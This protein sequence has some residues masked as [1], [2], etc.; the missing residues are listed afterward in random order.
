MAAVRLVADV[1][2]HHNRATAPL[3]RARRG[4]SRPGRRAAAGQR[5]LTQ[6]SLCPPARVAVE[7]RGI[8]GGAEYNSN[9]R[10]SRQSAEQKSTAVRFGAPRLVP[11]QHAA[12]RPRIR[13][14]SEHLDE[15]RVVADVRRLV[16]HAAHQPLVAQLAVDD[17]LVAH[18]RAAAGVGASV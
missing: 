15:R 7:A 16:A 17:P 2:A 8:N 5:V 13:P 3:R 9:P 6:R 1:P 10:L 4:R 18:D 12:K 11:S 14:R